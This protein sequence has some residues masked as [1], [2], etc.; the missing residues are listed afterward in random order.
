M[1]KKADWPFQHF[2]RRTVEALYDEHHE[3]V[4]IMDRA[5]VVVYYNARMAQLDGLD[6]AEA[7]GR[8]LTEIYDLDE[9]SSI[10]FRCLKTRRPV[11]DAALYYQT[12]SGN[13][14]NAICHAYPLESA[15]RI[16]GAIC[17]TLE[18]SFMT[19]SLE[20]TARNY[21]RHPFS[22]GASDKDPPG[23]GATHTMASL[24][25]E[26]QAFKAAMETARIGARTPSSVMICG[27][28]GT[29]KE[30]F[31]QAIHNNSVRRIKQFCPIN[32]AAIPETLLEGILFGTVRG[33]F[34][35]AVDRPGLFEVSS[36]GTIFLDEIHA[37][38]VNLQAKLLRVIQEKRVR[39]IGGPR[40]TGVDL[41]IISSINQK[42][43]VA[44]RNGHLRPD[45]YFRLAVL[46]LEIPALR[47]RQDDVA[48]LI[49][50]FIKIFNRKLQGRV[51]S[52]EPEFL[53]VMRRY[54]WPGNVRE[55]EHVVETCM[56][57][58]VIDPHKRRTLGL[59]H[60]QP[61]HL[62]RFLAKNAREGMAPAD[63]GDPIAQDQNQ[64]QHQ[65]RDKAVESGPEGI[66]P[67]GDE[68]RRQE[69]ELISNALK[70]SGGN[71][72]VAAKLLGLSRQNLF[73]REKRLAAQ[74][75]L[76]PGSGRNGTR[77]GPSS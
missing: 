1:S 26:S 3:G 13:R 72:A 34:T 47:F 63:P 68:L 29:G 55:L 73:S 11:S 75:A 76:P 20:K 17:Y 45:L 27:E 49:Q 28:T 57:F 41:K 53:E 46:F 6:P 65:A 32:C 38:P 21:A 71:H 35:G 61:A 36:G 8:R 44:L 25:G 15:G 33:A 60:I 39:R 67:L 4:L 51:N 37:M 18:Y 69:A 16:E 42:P 5:G 43:E 52:V 48:L 74:Q 70:A 62:R 2:S 14:V 59:A 58:A 40:E 54:S 10:S 19:E 50:N 31:A 77:P 9:D 30:L 12:R 66:K 22:R 7:L 56:N 24:V 23:N 64:D